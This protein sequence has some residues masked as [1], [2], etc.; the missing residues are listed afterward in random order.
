M[1]AN[2]TGPDD[3]AEDDRADDG[4]ELSAEEAAI[5]VGGR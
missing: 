2:A 4:G 5:H 3:A 1:V